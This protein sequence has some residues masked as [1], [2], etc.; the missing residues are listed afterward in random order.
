MYA[1]KQNI[2]IAVNTEKYYSSM[3]G[4]DNESWNVRDRHMMETLDRLIKFHGEKAKGIVWEHNTHIGD[5][6]A[7]GMSVG[8][9]VN[10]G[11][12]ARE[13]YGEENVYLAGFACYKG[14]VIAGKEWGA[15][16]K[17]M[18]VPKASADSIEAIL[19]KKNIDSAYILF[20]DETDS[21]YQTAINHRAIG[22][23][24]N[25]SREKYEN[26]APSVLSKRYDALIFFDKTKAL[27]PLHLH[28]DKHKLA[29]TYPF[30]L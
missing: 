2:L 13:E 1:K 9:M 25:P 16:M 23:V 3:I 28:T 21:L 27:H 7:T 17:V 24:Y 26:Y 4:F 12:L 6:R 15:P 10:I 30:N 5:A 18:K 29:A 20:G 22:V 19:H 11:Q 14:T 8:G